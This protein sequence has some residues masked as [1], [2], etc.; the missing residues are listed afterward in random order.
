AAGWATGRPASASA[1]KVLGTQLRGPLGGRE[2]ARATKSG[3]RA[4]FESL[5]ARGVRLLL[6]YGDAGASRVFYDMML[7]ESVE[8]GDLGGS[9]AVRV[10]PDTNHTFV[11]LASQAA[12]L[13]TVD[14]WI[15]PIARDARRVAARAADAVAAG[16]PS[17]PGG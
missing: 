11:S 1:R 6:A 5:A 17:G 2:E 12:L 7:R 13:R 4:E 10:L 16:G 8:R 15:A 3:L 14:E 9:V